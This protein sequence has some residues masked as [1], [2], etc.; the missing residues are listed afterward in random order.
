MISRKLI[1]P[2]AGAIV[3]PCAVG[4]AGAAAA[5]SPTA[6]SPAPA[7][8]ATGEPLVATSTLSRDVLLGKRLTVAGALVPAIAAETV[9]LQERGRYGWTVVARAE[10]AIAGS[11]ALQFRPRRLGL[12]S[13]RLQVSIAGGVYNSPTTRVNV[14]HKVLASWY[15]P[16]GTTACGETLTATTLGVANKTLPC[17]TLVTLRYRHRVLRVPVI[18]RGPYVT[19]RE[20]DLTWATKEALG[21]GDLTVLW[22]NR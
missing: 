8:G 19:G 18:D 6:A 9:A 10:D 7:S 22:A 21:A 20:Y 14:F 17:G 4:L 2:L 13:M 15:G 3:V 11:F 5:S 1:A 12:H 16:G